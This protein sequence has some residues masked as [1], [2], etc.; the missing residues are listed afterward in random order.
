M[1]GTEEQQ[2]EYKRGLIASSYAM[3]CLFVL[4]SLLLLVFKKMGPEKVRF[5]AGTP[6]SAKTSPLKKIILRG[7]HSFYYLLVDLFMSLHYLVY[8]IG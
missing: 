1:A 5:L 8:D 2:Q 3:I 4:W 7:I 6:P